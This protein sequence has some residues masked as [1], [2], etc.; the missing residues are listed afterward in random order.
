MR[1]FDLN[2]S[3]TAI[4]CLEMEIGVFPKMP[5]NKFRKQH[6]CGEIQTK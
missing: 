1:D 3:P 2:V 5:W 6:K 4:G